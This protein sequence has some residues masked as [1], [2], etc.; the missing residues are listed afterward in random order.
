MK[1]STTILLIVISMGLIF[2]SFGCA[3]EKETPK[4]TT[5]DVQAI[6]IKT[7]EFQRVVGWLSKDSVLLQTKAKGLSYFAEL[8]IYTGKKR[9]IFH[10]KESISEVQISPDYRNMLLYSAESSEKA[11]MRVIDLDDGNIV[12]SRET[13]PL[14]TNFYWNNESPE[15]IMLV[16]YSPEWDFHVENWD[17]TLNQ[18]VKVDLVSPFVSW[19]GDNLIISN[20]KDKPDDE[21]GNLYLQDIRDNSNKSLIVANIMQFAVHDNV[22]ITIEKSSDEKLLYEFRTI[23]F[24]NFYSYYSAREY[25]EL[26]TFVPY[27][28]AN[29]DKNAF[30]TFEPYESAKISGN[31]NEYKLV[32]VNP[33]TNKETTILDLMDN[34]PIL[35]YETGDLIL[36]GYLFDKVIDT[37]TGKMYN[38]VNTPTKSF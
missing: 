21:L 27:F 24:Q 25:D 16:I 22:L 9:A 4:K 31:Q 26:G 38:L 3:K 19:Y 7:K 29:F 18:V 2:I 35:S 23:G 1:K 13:N 30:L 10:T 8:N 14:T 5:K 37:K 33:T 28:D 36:Y 17:Y 34:Q 15:K 12:A 11:I 20:N 6:Q 32:K